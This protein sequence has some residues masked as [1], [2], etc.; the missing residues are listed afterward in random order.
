M[1][2]PLR[3]QRLETD[4]VLPGVPLRIASGGGADDEVRTVHEHFAVDC[5]DALRDGHA[6]QARAAREGML[7]DFLDALRDD[8]AG[9]ARA[10]REGIPPDFLDALRDGH[11]SI[12][13]GVLGQNAL[14]NDKILLVSHG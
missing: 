10:V 1:R 14:L 6:G 4:A 5:R 2:L 13:A 12:G 3:L 7:P 11:I 9:Q 8:H